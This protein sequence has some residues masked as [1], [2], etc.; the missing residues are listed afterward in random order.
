MVCGGCLVG[1]GGCLVGVGRLSGGFG[2]LSGGCVEAVWRVWR[3]CLK[4]C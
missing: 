2:R 1:C 3:G 4:G